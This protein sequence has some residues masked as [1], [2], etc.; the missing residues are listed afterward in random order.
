MSIVRAQSSVNAMASHSLRYLANCS[1]LFTEHDLLDRPRAARDAGFN[2]IEFWW[3]WPTEPVPSDADVERCMHMLRNLQCE[4][5]RPWE[6]A[7]ALI[8][9]GNPGRMSSVSFIF[10][11]Q[12]SVD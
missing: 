8:K 11:F 12:T 10:A 5:E 6:R 9:D 4:G 2:A 1:M 3:P 7:A